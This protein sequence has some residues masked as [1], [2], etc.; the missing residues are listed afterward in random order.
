MKRNVTW[1]CLLAALIVPGVSLASTISYTAT[2]IAATSTDWQL[3]LDFPK[4]DPSL[5]TLVSV[6]L[7]LDAACDSLVTVSNTSATSSSKGWAMSEV[8]VTAQGVGSL[9]DMVT[10]QIKF[11]LAPGGSISATLHATGSS[12][13]TFTDAATLAA[14]TGTGT[15]PLLTTAEA[16]TIVAYNGGN[17]S[18][19]QL[20]TASASGTVVYQYEVPEPMTLSLLA[21]GVP[22]LRRRGA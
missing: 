12:D 8:T 18:A 15:I 5:G 6:E 7:Q 13:D 1:V 4:F 3:P 19:T 11:T 22:F 16:Y 2:P 20:T 9:V 10:P 21:L 14:F 17:T